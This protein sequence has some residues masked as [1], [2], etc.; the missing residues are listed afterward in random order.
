MEIDRPEKLI[1]EHSLGKTFGKALQLAFYLVFTFGLILT[2]AHFVETKSISISA[3][4]VMGFGYALATMDTRAQIDVARNRKRTVNFTLGIRLGKWEELG[5]FTDITIMKRL[6]RNR[7]YSYSM[8]STENTDEFYDV[9]LL[10][11]THLKKWQAA[12]FK[13]VDDAKNCRN[14]IAENLNLTV[15][16]YSPQTRYRTQIRRR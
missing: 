15:A 5:D 3:V 7:F 16:N 9:F 4:L 10:N 14:S 11:K 12:R 6:M 2:F 1:I 13:N 8:N